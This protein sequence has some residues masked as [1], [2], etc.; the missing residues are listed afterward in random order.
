[1]GV[2]LA[3]CKC[4]L[5]PVACEQRELRGYV[6]FWLLTPSLL[7]AFAAKSIKEWE[8]LDPVAARVGLFEDA[9]GSPRFENNFPCYASIR[10]RLD[11]FFGR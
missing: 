3:P 4:L 6:P 7:S 11:L 10:I 1:M 9:V 2:A 8:F 5:H